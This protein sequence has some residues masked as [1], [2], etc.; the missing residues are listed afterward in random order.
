MGVEPIPPASQ[1]GVPTAYTTDTMFSD[2]FRR[3]RFSG[4]DPPAFGDRRPELN[5]QGC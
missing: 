3:V 5:P 1:A 2:T 4:R